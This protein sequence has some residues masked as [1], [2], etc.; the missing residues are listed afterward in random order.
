MLWALFREGTSTLIAVPTAILLARL[1]SPEEFGTA[2]IAYFFVA[3]SS[4]LNQF[5]LNASLVR[6]KDV[7]PKHRSTAFVVNLVVGMGTWVALAVSAPAIAGYVRSEQAGQILPVAALSFPILAF[8]TVP[9]TL[10]AREIRYREIATCE[11]LSSITSSLVSLVL[12]WNGFSFFSVVYAALA[13]DIARTS[14]RVYFTGWRPS[15]RFSTSAFRELWSFGAGMY[16][17]NLLNYT[18]GNVDNVIVGRYLGMSALGLY[19]KAFRL[20]S[21]IVA[22]INLSGPT[23]SLRIFSLIHE[24][25]E[26]FRR[27]YRRVVTAVTMVGYP[28][29]SALIVL[30]PELFRVL[31]G[32]RWTGAVLPFQILC[33]VGMLRL[34]NTYASSATQ[35]KGMIWAEV[36]RQTFVTALLAASVAILCRWGV[37]GAA[38]GV[39]VSTAVTTV[40]MQRLTQRLTGFDWRDLIVPQV[41][42]ALCS[43]GLALSVALPKLALHIYA[44]NL[45]PSVILLLG[46]ALSGTFFITFLLFSGFHEVADLVCD[47]LNDTAPTAAR[48]IRG[49]IRRGLPVPVSQ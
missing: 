18:A 33:V 28:S 25:P 10:L 16:V 27:G 30:A 11:A 40:L 14:A 8:G 46:T 19:D 35:A 17:K 37:A 24:E 38:A 45:A 26:R 29:F 39:L 1:L 4:R 34:L 42:A 15:L 32:E 20:M 47:T 5:G 7:G 48:R 49:L 41:P 31:F 22:G 44:P 36:G 3:L 6:M 9:G 43:I 21:K 2:A 13:S 12:A 23:T